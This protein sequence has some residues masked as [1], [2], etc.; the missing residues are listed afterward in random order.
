MRARRRLAALA[1]FTANVE[2]GDIYA[3]RLKG[4]ASA[5]GGGAYLRLWPE[6]EDWNEQIQH[7]YRV[8]WRQT[9]HRKKAPRWRGT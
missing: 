2:Q 1:A 9:R 6:A 4:I 7:A 3:T 5:A 8:A